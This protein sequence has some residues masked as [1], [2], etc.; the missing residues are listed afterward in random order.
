MAM[1]SKGKK[2]L[3]IKED[4]ERRNINAK[5]IMDVIKFS[6]SGIKNYMDDGK[7]FILYVFCSII[8]IILGFIFKVNGLEWILIISMLGIILSVELLNTGIEKACDAITKEYTPYIKIAKDC[9]SGATFIMFI[10]ALIL[11]IIIFAPKIVAAFTP[12]LY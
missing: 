12:V 3:T 5:S 9:G 10:V 1:G 4:F 6:L 2:S 8:E 7:S 11:N